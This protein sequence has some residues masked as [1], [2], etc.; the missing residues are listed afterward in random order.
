MKSYNSREII[1]ILKKN[2]WIEKGDANGSH[3]F[4]I[5]PDKPNLGKVTIPHPRKSF[6]IK[7][8]LSIKKQT[9]VDF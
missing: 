9:G 2:G 6:P 3:V 7:T 8:L 5:N 4:M 1:R